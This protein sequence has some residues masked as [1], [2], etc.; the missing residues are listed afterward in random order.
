M[1]TGFQ[2][3]QNIQKIQNVDLTGGQRG[4]NYGMPKVFTTV[5]AV[6]TKDMTGQTFGRLTVLARAGTDR[7][8]KATWLCR[9]ACGNADGRHRQG[10]AAGATPVPAAVS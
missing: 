3:K 1:E 5:R 4:Y 8:R 7:D 6:S 2:L 9:C 10:D